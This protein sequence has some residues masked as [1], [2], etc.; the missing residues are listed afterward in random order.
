[1][2]IFTKDELAALRRSDLEMEK[3]DRE[4]RNPQNLK[5]VKKCH[6][7]KKERDECRTCKEPRASEFTPF[8]V[9]HLLGA[10]RFEYYQEGDVLTAIGPHREGSIRWKALQKIWPD[11]PGWKL[12][13]WARVLGKKARKAKSAI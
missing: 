3:R 4:E 8:C 6:A 7:L 10:E 12:D 5:T 11:L 9:R 13:L 2:G 1:M